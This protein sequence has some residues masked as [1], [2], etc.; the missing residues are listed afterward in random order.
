MST[1]I[2]VLEQYEVK[3]V[4]WEIILNYQYKANNI[5]K[6]KFKLKLCPTFINILL[7]LV[8]CFLETGRF[9][10]NG[11]KSFLLKTKKLCK[12]NFNA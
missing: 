8:I 12:F 2:C 4:E 5:K 11:V 3:F 10:V 6:Y 1:S 7:E 9:G